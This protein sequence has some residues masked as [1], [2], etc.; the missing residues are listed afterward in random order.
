MYLYLDESGDLGFK[1]GTKHFVMA[2]FTTRNQKAVSKAIARVK[3]K[4]LPRKLKGISEI[5][6]SRAPRKFARYVY[7]A[8]AKEN[9]AIYVTIVPTYK[10]PQH[11]RCEEGSLYNYIAGKTLL[12]APLGESSEIYLYLDKRSHKGLTTREFNEH[13]RA[14][15]LHRFDR[16][17]RF[18]IYHRPSET[19]NCLQAA[20]FICWAIYLK[21]EWKDEEWYQILKDK[22]R[23]EVVED[24]A[25]IIEG[26]RKGLK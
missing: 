22:I 24:F 7:K 8:L 15:V 16:K 13:L 21:Y 9:I 14:R 4:K 2:L 3:R 17:T 19:L 5:K 1:K 25:E 18:E 6:A 20:D 10:I 12:S 26:L 11:L 23:S